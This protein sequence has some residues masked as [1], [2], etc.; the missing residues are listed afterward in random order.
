MIEHIL[1]MFISYTCMTPYQRWVAL[2]MGVFPYHTQCW[3]VA[4]HMGV[5]PYHTQCWWVALHMGVLPYHT[6]CWWASNKAC[7]RREMWNMCYFLRE[8]WFWFYF[9]RELWAE[10]PFLGLHNEKVVQV[11]TC[12]NIVWIAV[13]WHVVWRCRAII[14][15]YPTISGIWYGPSC[16][17]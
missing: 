11:R 2:Y 13:T 17:G 8:L 6:Q 9:F 14:I 5:F 1:V 16:F 15:Q 3:W 4:L 12:E 7:F 10:P